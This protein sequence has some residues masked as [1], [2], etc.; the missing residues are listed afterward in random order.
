MEVELLLHGV[1]HGQQ[2]N[3]IADE[4]SN[5]G[6]FYDNSTE[7]V[8][9]VIETKKNEGKSYAYYSY[10]RYKG[11][12]EAGGRTGS[13]FGLTLRIDKYYKDAI[14]IY[15]LLDML[16]MRYIVGTVL[17]PLGEG[18][19]YIISSFE[20][21]TSEIEQI[22]KVLIQ[23]VQTTCLPSQFIGIDDSFI[24]H[25]NKV[26]IGTLWEVNNT[27]IF[28]FI[29][30]YSKVV[31]SPDYELNVEKEYKKKLQIAEE[32]VGNIVSQKDK[33]I[34]ELKVLVDNQAKRI[35][36]LEQE[37]KDKDSEIQNQKKQ[38][39][40]LQSVAKIKE[41]IISLADY[42]RIHDTT[43]NLPL[44]QYDH[45]NYR[46]G[47]ISCA[48]VS[49]VLLLCI[50]GLFRTP[51][52]NTVDEN[53]LVELADQIKNIKKENQY[54]KEQLRKT[55]RDKASNAESNSTVNPVS[56]RIDVKNYNGEDLDASA[57]YEVCIK[58]GQILYNGSGVWE[59][60]NAN[61]VSGSDKDVRI[62]IKPTGRGKV[63]LSYK[64]SDANSSCSPRTFNTKGQ[65]GTPSITITPNVSE[66]EVG[67][68]Y[69]FSVSGYFGQ[70]RWGVDGF[71]APTDRNANRIKVKSIDNGK[72]IATISYTP[73]PDEEKKVSKSFTIKKR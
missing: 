32:N 62:V 23:L 25:I 3:G 72:T 24:N 1:P 37:V 19:K 59:I 33:T 54:L 28:S 4:Q 70:G 36:A 41:P 44:P 30:K 61:I 58:N 14:H 51:T 8:K 66:I 7:S 42:F 49:V 18:Y 73:I 56:L 9:F 39:N 21:K 63:E 52:V 12:I 67:K 31:L 53:K 34:N 22:Q 57:K 48:I 6:L 16:F 10:L 47:I 71:S 69:T 2:Y 64:P 5:M 50:I 35:A 65:T 38:G 60:K 29:K 15:N 27:S 45:K 55:E 11:I 40:L 26:P 13:Y 20:T 43:K 17:N 68:E 46:I